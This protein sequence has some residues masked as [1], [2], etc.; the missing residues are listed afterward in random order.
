VSTERRP[1]L[2][3]QSPSATLDELCP[4][5][6]ISDEFAPVLLRRFGI[7][8]KDRRHHLTYFIAICEVVREGVDVGVKG[9]KSDGVTRA[10]SRPRQD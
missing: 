3:I 2:G 6:R 8:I 4:K 5:V 1:V 9:N 10:A 7:R